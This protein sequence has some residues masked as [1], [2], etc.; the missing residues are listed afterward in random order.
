MA[1][2]PGESS[3]PSPSAPAAA[4]EPAKKGH[5][6]LV[7]AVRGLMMLLG[8]LSGLVVTELVFRARD[9]AAYPHLN[10]YD[11]DEALG[12]VLE[13]GC[14]TRVRVATNR[15]TDVHVSS[16]GTRGPELGA[17]ADDEILVVGDSQ[18]FGLG[19]EDDE[20]FAAV[21]GRETQHPV[22][23]G[24]VPTYGPLEYTALAQRFLES[25]HVHTVVWVVNAAN[26]FFEHSR[27]DRERHAVWDHWAVRAETMPSAILPFPGREWLYQRS[28]AFLAFRRWRHQTDDTIDAVRDLGFP[29]EGS[30]HDLVHDGDDVAEQHREADEAHRAA[31]ATHTQLVAQLGSS[32]DTA[33]DHIDEAIEDS[34]PSIGE[35]RLTADEY[36]ELYGSEILLAAREQPGD[37]I[38]DDSGEESRTVLVTASLLARAQRMRRSWIQRNLRSAPVQ[39]AVSERDAA[40]TALEAERARALDETPVPSVLEPRLREIVDLCA[41]HGA[42]LLVVV[43]PLDVMVSDAEFAKYGAEP[44]DVS[45][46]RVLLGDVVASA[47]RMGARALDTTDALR[48]AEPGA[49]L[50]GDLHL[51]VSGH[52]A[53][54]AAIR[55]RLAGP[56]PLATPRGG[57]PEGRTPI[58]E[59]ERFVHEPEASVAGSTAAH[60]VTH[61]LG[62][63]LR[64][65][66]RDALRNHPTG[67]TLVAG[68]HGEAMIVTTEAATTLTA[69]VFAGE[70]LVADFHWTTRT[71]R[72]TV[73]WP[74]GAA[75]PEMAFGEALPAARPTLS[76][77][78]PDARLCACHREV[79]QLEEC[80]TTEGYPDCAPSCAELYGEATPA[81]MAQYAAS[82][83]DLLRCA[84]GEPDTRAAC[85]DGQVPALAIGRCLALCAPAAPG[86]PEVTCAEGTCT[87]WQGAFVCVP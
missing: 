39:T 20:T 11:A 8:V 59:P 82:C 86:R 50:D 55:E 18:V 69:P 38:G 64:I 48:A 66:C 68:G 21:L 77:S 52:A 44:T 83:A 49:F 70:D 22:I 71:Q 80:A 6:A 60:C 15:P 51:S 74:A 79:L 7:W 42:E 87:P 45:A 54:A 67:A 46:G 16:A 2:R 23:N 5:R 34:D 81:C 37:I 28:H 27:P 63:W 65:S 57:L 73:H 75:A 3:T 35:A 12:V 30:L 85:P 72:L 47:E 78:E 56:V 17:P 61:L 10:C 32:L 9:D 40:R 25:R 36:D 58:P 4:A 76:V 43:L 41:E 84:R 14:E 13:P 24:G 53:V 62:E 26:D 29:S 19:V 31:I 33:E 1:D